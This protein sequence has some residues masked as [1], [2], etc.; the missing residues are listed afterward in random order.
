MSTFTYTNHGI[1][2]ISNFEHENFPYQ[3]LKN[4]API[5]GKVSMYA[6]VKK[7]KIHYSYFHCHG[8]LAQTP[9][10]ASASS[11]STPAVLLKASF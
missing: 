5:I 10:A 1:T 4:N 7:V 8:Y 11:A 3:M 2:T 6:C 9:A